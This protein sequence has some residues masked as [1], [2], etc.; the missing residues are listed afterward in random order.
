MTEQSRSLVTRV[1]EWPILFGLGL[2]TLGNAAVTA[3]FGLS[4]LGM[5]AMQ[6][7]YLLLVV[8]AVLSAFGVGKYRQKK[9]ELVEGHS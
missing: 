4:G 8:G 7:A 9:A 3:W 6:K 5:T 1:T 2:L